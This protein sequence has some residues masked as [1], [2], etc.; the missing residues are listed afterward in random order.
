MASY[1][2]ADRQSGDA[3]PSAGFRRCF[4]IAACVFAIATLPAFAAS[5]NAL[6]VSF[7][8]RD[9][10]VYVP[11]RLPPVGRRALVVV[12]HGA[13]G[14]AERIE[15][16]ASESALDMDPVADAG[17]FIVAY[18]NGTTLSPFFGSDALGWNSGGGCCGLP[19]RSGVDDIAYIEGAVS[20]LSTRF[21][22]DP[23]RV[24]GI[25]HSNGAMMTA[26]VVC[27]AGVF[28]AAIPISGPL[29]IDGDRCPAA[30]GRRIL[31]IHGADDENVPLAGGFGTK[32]IAKIAFQSEARSRAIFIAAG[33]S[34][35]LDVVPGADHALAN[36]DATVTRIEGRSIAEKAARFFGLLGD[37]A[38]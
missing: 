2:R 22:I 13:G 20:D 25:G 29:D 23:A 18:L 10:L 17:G 4:A 36:I 19:A 31:A 1:D 8:G 14:N 3:I 32:G 27:E 5:A 35:D 21:G 11:A 34:Y 30:R 26:R 38:R 24:Y 12:L 7:G 9:M 37:P 16:A 28:A 15:S 33:A 6:H